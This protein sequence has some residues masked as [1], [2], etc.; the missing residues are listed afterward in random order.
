MNTVQKTTCICFS[1]L[2]LCVGQAVEWETQGMAGYYFPSDGLWDNGWSG[3]ARIIAWEDDLGLALSAGMMQWDVEN[4]KNVITDGALYKKWHAWQGDVQYFPLGLSLL[5]RYYFGEDSPESKKVQFEAG[6]HYL[7]A[8]DTLEVVQTE[9]VWDNINSV[10]NTT[11]LP[12]GA[13]C[14]DALV[15]RLGGSFQWEM[16][17]QTFGFVSGGYQFDITQGDATASSLSVKQELDLSA[18]YV[19]FGIAFLWQ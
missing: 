1:L 6:L 9:Q 2:T 4:K 8:R 7:F 16:S 14:D 18:F 17:E 12:V 15:A 19:H 10:F 3:E 13:D 5:E 11:H